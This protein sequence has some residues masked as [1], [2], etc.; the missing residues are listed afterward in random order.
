MKT[1]ATIALVAASLFAGSA[2]AYGD[3]L[4]DHPAIVAAKQQEQ[5]TVGLTRAEVKAGVLGMDDAVRGEL[6]DYAAL[7]EASERAL[8]RNEVRQ[9]L[10]RHVG[11]GVAPRVGVDYP[12]RG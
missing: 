5:Q 11:D 3:D 9:E 4:V 1:T 6:I 7:D 12:S 10:A 8:T 2:M